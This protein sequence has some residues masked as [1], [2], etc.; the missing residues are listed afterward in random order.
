[1]LKVV[2]IM[3]VIG[4]VLYGIDMLVCRISPKA[5]YVVAI[6]NICFLPV[7]IVTFILTQK[8]L[9]KKLRVYDLTVYFRE[10]KERRIS[11]DSCKNISEFILEKQNGTKNANL[12]PQFIA[13]ESKEDLGSAKDWDLEYATSIDDLHMRMIGLQ[14]CKNLEEFKKVRPDLG[15][16]TTKTV[17][18]AEEGLQ[19][20]IPQG[21]P[22]INDRE[23]ENR[24]D[25]VSVVIPNGVKRIGEYAFSGCANLKSIVILS[26]VKEIG[27]AAFRGCEKL[28]EI[29][30]PAGVT[31]IGGD[32]FYDCKN[33]KTIVIPESVQEIGIGATIGCFNLDSS[34]RGLIHSKEPRP[35][36]E[37]LECMYIDP[38]NPSHPPRTVTI[39]DVASR[40]YGPGYGKNK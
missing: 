28:T 5:G 23:F 37:D 11:K 32:A 14:G 13:T 35:T 33:L 29:E 30:I 24:E 8:Y 4:V 18:N 40:L 15:E 21:T 25:I 34:I 12:T 31:K 38:V 2:L 22:Q 9:E 7:G 6:F 1:M 26:G 16:H 10:E 39:E 20:V 27:Y 17:T 19:L 36:A 3:A